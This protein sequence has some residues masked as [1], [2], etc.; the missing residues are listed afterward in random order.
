MLHNQWIVRAL[1]LVNMMAVTSLRGGHRIPR[2]VHDGVI[3]PRVSVE[4]VGD[5]LFTRMI[6]VLASIVTDLWPT[7][8]RLPR[9]THYGL[10]DRLESQLIV[11]VVVVLLGLLLPC[12]SHTRC[13]VHVG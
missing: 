4:I 8:C 1:T 7:D 5:V 9:P 12:C 10:L 6:F 3:R 2:Q 11:A 13:Q